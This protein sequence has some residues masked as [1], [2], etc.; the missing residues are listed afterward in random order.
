M[1]R[2]EKNGVDLDECGKGT[3]KGTGEVGRGS[4]KGKWEGVRG[5]M[6]GGRVKGEGGGED[7]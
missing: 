3:G 4:W 2:E 5:T 1:G 7:G 6:D